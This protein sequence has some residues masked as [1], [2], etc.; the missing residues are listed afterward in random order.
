M[1]FVLLLFTFLLGIVATIFA[2]ILGVY[3]AR[4]R[5]GIGRA[6]SYMLFGES[7]GCLVITFFAGAHLLGVIDTVPTLVSAVARATAFAIA[8]ASTAHLGYHVRK[9]TRNT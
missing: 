3:F 8:I 4:S 1:D 9:I 6:V 5:P 7:V 2:A